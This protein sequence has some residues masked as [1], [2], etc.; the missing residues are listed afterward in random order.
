MYYCEN[1][2]TEERSHINMLRY[3]LVL[4]VFLVSIPVNATNGLLF[5]DIINLCNKYNLQAKTLA[6]LQDTSLCFADLS[7]GSDFLTFAAYAAK[8]EFKTTK[9]LIHSAQKAVHHAYVDNCRL[10]QD[11][12]K[13]DKRLQKLYHSI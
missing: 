9:K 8:Y 1:Q 4:S 6:E 11:I 2:H 12:K 3:L 13:L 10:S 7:K 5:A